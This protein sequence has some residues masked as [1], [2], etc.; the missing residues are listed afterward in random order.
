MSAATNARNVGAK[1]PPDVGPA[2]TAFAVCVLKE[3]VSAGV[4]VAV[5]TEVVNKGLNAPALNDV[6]VPVGATPL[7]AAVINPS[8]L[9]VMLAYVN[10]PTFTFTVGRSATTR[11]RN[12]GIAATPVVGPAHTVLAVCVAIA[13]DNAGVELGLDTKVVMMEPIL[14]ELNEVTV[15]IPLTGTYADTLPPE[16]WKITLR[17]PPGAAGVVLFKFGEET[18]APLTSNVDPKGPAANVSILTK[19]SATI[20]S[21]PLRLK[22]RFGVIGSLL[23]T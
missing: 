15:P 17:S 23:C 20:G 5:A 13:K 6:T 21:I 4:V 3:N 7:A 18:G 10:E 8:A 22:S 14:P 1:A 16:T 9:T 19:S 12:A 11:A 2:N